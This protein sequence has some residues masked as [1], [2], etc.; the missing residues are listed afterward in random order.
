MVS[1]DD[2]RGAP[3]TTPPP[4]DAGAAADRATAGD[5]AAFRVTAGDPLPLG[6][7]VERDAVNFSVFTQHGTAVDLLFFDRV[8]DA[9][10][11]RTFRLDP[12]HHRTFNYWHVRVHG[13]RAGQ[14]YGYRVFG[15]SDPAR[16]HRFD[17]TKVLVDPYAKAIVYGDAYS[18]VAASGPGDN[19]AS[20]MKGLVT[21]HADFDWDGVEPPRVPASRRVI[22]EMHVR[23][24]TR[25]PSSGVAH[26]GT[27]AGVVEKIPYL[28]ALGVTTVQLLPVFQFDE[29]EVDNRDPV[30]N[31]RLT[32]YWGY[33]PLG[34]FA[35]HRGYYIEDWRAMRHLTGF[36]DMV[37]E[38]HR[39]G[40]EVILD[41]V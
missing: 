6:A 10:P 12:G 3:A 40:L 17:P 23:G 2:E 34:F 24:F 26:P 28:K 25:H 14:I 41:V 36:R 19:A 9:Y 37:R 18:R 31:K 27:F 16:G 32:N 1:H 15:P 35:P 21:D 5:P 13:A 33:S 29:N 8:D 22:Y 4:D 30:T 39:A 11:S 38:L 20:A 7:T